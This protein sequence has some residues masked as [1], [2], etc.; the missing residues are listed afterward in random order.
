MMPRHLQWEYIVNTKTK[1]STVI[2]VLR[3]TLLQHVTKS[4][5]QIHDEYTKKM[6]LCEEMSWLNQ[7]WGQQ[8]P[9]SSISSKYW[10]RIFTMK[11]LDTRRELYQ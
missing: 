6:I 8:I 11:S 9:N 3:W 2:S 7:Y 1:R 10:Q 4:L 5:D